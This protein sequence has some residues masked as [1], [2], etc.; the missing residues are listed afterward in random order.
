MSRSSPKVRILTFDGGGVRGLSSLLILR[1]FVERL[2]HLKASSTPNTPSSPLRPCDIFDFIV[3]TGTGGIS[4]LFLG[5]LHMTVDQAIEEYLRMAR[6]VFKSPSFGTRRLLRWGSQTAFDGKAL[7][8]C[9]RSTV[10]Q[11]LGD[12]DARLFEASV[13]PCRVAVL[14]ATSAHADA[15]PHV[16]RNDVAT[17][18]FRITDVALATSATAGL[19]PAI[20]LS[21]PPIEFIDPGL[22]GYNNPTEVALSQAHKIWPHRDTIVLSI[23]TGTQRIVDAAVRNR[24]GKL[25]DLSQRLTESC[26]A[27]HDRL[28]HS[29]DL[30]SYFR[31]SVDHGLDEVGMKEWKEA[32]GRRLTG[33]TS[34]YLRKAELARHLNLCVQV[35]HGDGDPHGEW[36]LNSDLHLIDQIIRTTSGFQWPVN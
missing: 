5:R 20:S 34:A 26:K 7:E 23:G 11:Y 28:I 15:P 31:F 12:P 24:W 36:E 18:S 8:K 1:E 6:T 30:L 29:Q 35:V 32:A 33:I 16:F 17:P 25:A 10:V 4:A 19:F 27:P 14:A 9:L 3:G 2:Q 21:Q 22:A 13:P